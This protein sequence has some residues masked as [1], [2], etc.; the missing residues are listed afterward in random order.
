MDAFG[1]PIP[2]RVVFLLGQVAFTVLYNARSGRKVWF[3]YEGVPEARQQAQWTFEG[4][5]GGEI[6]L[7]SL[8]SHYLEN[9]LDVLDRTVPDEQSALATSRRY[10][11]KPHLAGTPQD[12]ET[13]KDFLR[14]LQQELGI[15]HACRLPIYSAGLDEGHAATLNIST[16]TEPTAWI[17]TYYP[18]LNS[19]LNHSLEILGEDGKPIWTADL[20]EVADGTD[21]DAAEHATAVLAWHGIS[22]GGEAQGKLVYVNHGRKEDYDALVEAGTLPFISTRG[23]PSPGGS[24]D[25]LQR[26]D[27]D[28]SLWR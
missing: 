1:H 9:L 20:E 7:V 4:L 22:R 12:L 8:C 3:P 19:P 14:H 15:G 25:R 2:H 28:C 11:S 10:A 26:K 16:Y 21:P 5:Q 23:F 27:C 24:R 17:N 13:A 6:V 18:I